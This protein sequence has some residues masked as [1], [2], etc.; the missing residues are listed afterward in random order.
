MTPMIII[1]QK[2]QEKTLKNL[3]AV[4]VRKQIGLL[5]KNSIG[6]KIRQYCWARYNFAPVDK[7][8]IYSKL[9]VISFYVKVIYK[10]N[11]CFSDINFQITSIEGFN[12][13][14]SLLWIWCFYGWLSRLSCLIRWF[15]IQHSYKPDLRAFGK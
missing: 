15:P 13:T 9:L 8:F 4:K 12:K 11:N 5:A 10:C 6:K 7:K 3:K 14:Y 1:H 2:R